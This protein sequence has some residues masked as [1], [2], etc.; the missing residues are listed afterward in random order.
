MN[1]LQFASIVTFVIF[2]GRKNGNLQLPR[3]WLHPFRCFTAVF[4]ADG[5]QKEQDIFQL[6]VAPSLYAELTVYR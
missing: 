1:D 4:F 2:E 3:N 5:T 6:Q